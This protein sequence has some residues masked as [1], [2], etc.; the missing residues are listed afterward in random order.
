[1]DDRTLLEKAAKVGGDSIRWHE[2]TQ[3]FTYIGPRGFT[4]WNPLTDDGDALRL[5][6]KLRLCLF[7]EIPRIGIGP[8]LNGPEVYVEGGEDEMA[9]TR[10][11]IVRAAASL[12]DKAPCAGTNCGTTT[13]Q[14]SVECIAE[15]ARACAPRKE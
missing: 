12:G 4:I 15:H 3:S 5:A 6:V 1:M 8:M 9:A 7:L 11:A 13:G 14:H 2:F 10:R